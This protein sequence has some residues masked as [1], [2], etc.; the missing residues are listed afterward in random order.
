MHQDATGAWQ[1][2]VTFTDLPLHSGQYSVSAYLFDSTGLAVY[3]EWKDCA[4]F[5]HI[6]H[7]STPGL[8]RLPHVWS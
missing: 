2:T 3:E 4:R 1:A 8:V 5:Q 7:T 6:L